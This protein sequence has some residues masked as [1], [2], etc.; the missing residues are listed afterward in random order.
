[1]RTFLASLLLFP[2]ITAS[3]QI[4]HEG[5]RFPEQSLS[6]NA[7]GAAIPAALGTRLPHVAAW[8]HQTA[9]ELHALCCR[10]ASLKADLKGRLH[11]ACPGHPAP[12][13]PASAPPVALV[14]QASDTFLLHSLPGAKR[15]I[16]LDFDGHTTTGTNW[17]A[18]RPS[19]VTPPYSLDANTGNFSEAELANIQTVWQIIAE[20][21]KPFSVD[22]TT[23]DPGLEAIRKTSSSDAFFGIR[24]C[25]GGDSLT[26]YK[27]EVGGIAFLNTFGSNIDTPAF[28]FPAQLG[29]IAKYVAD[30]ASHEIGHTLGL[31]HDG[32]GTTEYYEGHGDWAP[33]MGVGYEKSVVQWSKGE[34]T[35]ANNRQDDLAIIAKLCPIRAD[36]RGDDILRASPLTGTS[37]TAS[38]VI[39]TRADADLFRFVAGAG[40]TSFV[41]TPSSTSPNLKAELTLYNGVGDLVNSF[42]SPDMGA[43]LNA[44]L[45]QGTYYLAVDGIGTG[46]PASGFNDYGSLGEYALTG[47]VPAPTTQAPV[48]VADLSGPLTGLPPLEVSFSSAGSSDPDGTISSYDWDFGNGS[49]SNAANPVFTY[50]T[51]GTYT[52]SLV[53]TDD[54]GVSSVP[55]TVKVVVLNHPRAIVG[56]I[57]LTR[58]RSLKG[59]RA[60]ADVMVRD[61][62]GN[63]R[64]GAT[65]SVRWSGLTQATQTTVTN[66]S[67]VARFTSPTSSKQGTFILTV[68]NV[69]CTGF[70]YLPARNVESTRAISSR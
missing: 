3:A 69:V 17:N 30:A 16:Y 56:Q 42:T 70:P 19:I 1:L 25:I 63:P 49:G 10:D 52:A 26:W 6:R 13:A 60:F 35:S 58:T 50:S 55:V 18:Q 20:D 67:G 32:A 39:E 44:N 33:I 24:V 23:Q 65:V 41:V 11:Y 9:P 15:V 27:A 12:S 45:P 53:V 48:A 37:F 59:I 21:F 29:G 2:V 7:S 4:N 43:I 34:Y 57:A 31:N 51:P 66:A 22:V 8:Y 14:A 5:L 68:T 47:S 54:G 62:N 38:G 64:P 61:L 46:P 36:L 28:V 40:T